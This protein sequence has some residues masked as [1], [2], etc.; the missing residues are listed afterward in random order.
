M[1]EDRRLY[2]LLTQA[3][4]ALSK[5]AA[6]TLSARLDISPVQCG[7]LM[8]VRKH[9]GCL[10]KEL[11]DGLGLNSSAITGLVARMERDELLRREACSEDGRASRLHLTARGRRAV[12]AALP[13]VRAL[14]TAMT[15][16]FTAEE[17]EVVS[18]FLVTMVDRFSKEDP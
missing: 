16:G 10:L 9:E 11:S 3:E 2:F 18:R 6:A 8:F 14:N 17:L 1:R 15:A 7:A 12:E 4:H 13:L 5:R